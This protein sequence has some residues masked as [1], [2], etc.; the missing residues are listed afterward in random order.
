MPSTAFLVHDLQLC[1]R[2]A[3]NH[4]RKTGSAHRLLA[5]PG[6]SVKISTVPPPPKKKETGP[7]I[8]PGALNTSIYLWQKCV[9]LNMTSFTTMLLFYTLSVVI[10]LYSLRLSQEKNYKIMYSIGRKARRLY[11]GTAQN[12]R[13][14]GKTKIWLILLPSLKLAEILM[15]IFF[16]KFLSVHV[17][18]LR[19]RTA[20]SPTSLCIFCS[21]STEIADLHVV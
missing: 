2:D 16:L 18:C 12:N 17:N 11:L 1:C 5:G 10:V 9:L 19:Q 4:L 20:C 6:H 13:Q 8:R 3:T 15:M 21:L 7:C 14:E